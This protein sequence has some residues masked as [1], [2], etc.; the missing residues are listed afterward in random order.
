MAGDHTSETPAR[1]VSFQF[2]PAH[3]GRPDNDDAGRAHAQFQFTPAHG[4]RQ[5]GDEEAAVAAAFQFTPAHGGR[6]QAVAG[7]RRHGQVSIH[8]RAWRATFRAWYRISIFSRFNSRPRMAGDSMAFSHC[9]IRLFQFTPAHGGRRITNPRS[10]VVAVSIHARA[11]R[12]TNG[13][14]ANP[15]RTIKFQFTPAHGG[16]LFFLTHIALLFS[17]NSRPRMAGD[18]AE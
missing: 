13:M 16:R 15:A 7:L 5:P 9:L 14:T 17:F 10:N 4:G 6:P 8:A 3:G 2:T 18:I 11:W 12:A 1:S